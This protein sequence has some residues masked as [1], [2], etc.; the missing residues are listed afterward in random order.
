MSKEYYFWLNFF[1]F[2]S[3]ILSC[4]VYFKFSVKQK[5]KFYEK[6]KRN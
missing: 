4:F 6:I 2:I 1:I 5:I 3:W